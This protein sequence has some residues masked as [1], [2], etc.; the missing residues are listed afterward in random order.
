MRR[1]RIIANI[2]TYVILAILVVIWLYPILWIFLNAFR[3]EYNENGDLIG[4]V[5]SNYIPKQLGFEN[6]K[7]L[8]TETHFLRQVGNTLI[9]SVFSCILSTLLTL[10]T[11]YIM[12]KIKFKMRKPFMNLAMILGL[13]PGFMSMI[14]IYFILKA[15]GLTQTLLALILCYSAGAGL[16]FYV[17]KGFFDT[18]PNA[19]V[20]SAKLDGATQAQIFW[21]IIL[22]L[23]KPIIIYTALLAFTGPWMDF[24][25]ARVILGEANTDLHTV[26]VGLYQMMYGAHA[27]NN[28]FTTFA[29]GCVCIAVPIVTLFLCMQKYYIEGATAGAVKG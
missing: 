3:C 13:F 25:F 6:F 9:V 7:K 15:L 16:G 8:F 5:V 4:I 22:P 29:A 20:E 21:H 27:D 26:A 10:S 2:A 14:A 17:A 11:A 28:I 1:H 24:I 12:S 18:V 19:L 23:S